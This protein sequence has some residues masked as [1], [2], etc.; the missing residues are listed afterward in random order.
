DIRLFIAVNNKA[1]AG[2]VYLTALQ[3]EVGSQVSEW[4]LEYLRGFGESQITQ[5][6]NLINLRVKEGD[7]INQINISPESILIAGNKIQ[8]T[9]QTYIENSVI[10]TAQIKDAAI[11]DA[12]IGNLSANKITTG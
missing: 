4:G 5:L 3:A 6:T 10:G 9:G 8:I 7:V 12:K 2:Y 1:T 11:T